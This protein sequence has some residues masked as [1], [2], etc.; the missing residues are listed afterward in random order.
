MILN[1]A[2][3][4]DQL[5]DVVAEIQAVHP[6]IQGLVVDCRNFDDGTARLCFYAC[7]PDG[8]P[9]GPVLTTM[10]IG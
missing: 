4:G 7:D 2:S 5:D 6:E 8:D 1:V 9:V 10:E 3:F